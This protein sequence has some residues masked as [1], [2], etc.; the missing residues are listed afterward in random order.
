MFK[1]VIKAEEGFDE[2]TKT[3]VDVGEA[4]TL[5]FEHSLISLSKWESKYQIPFL[6]GTEKTPEE[7]FGYLEA[8]LITPNVGLE[9]LYRC[10]KQDLDSIH[11][12][13]DSSQSAT[14][15]GLMPETR[16]PREVIT[17]ELIYFWMISFQI[18]W[19]AE[20]WHLNRLFALIR[21]CNIKNSKPKKM[22]RREM[23]EQNA[24][25][26]AERRAQLG[27]KG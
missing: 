8:M 26:N 27:T 22:S 16:G 25:L 23:A 20:H 18:P 12:Y 3:F 10:S 17:S 13:I 5:E 1:L 14:T 6:S 4:L 11:K 15:F 7:I 24:R 21:I 19:E 9:D 2:K